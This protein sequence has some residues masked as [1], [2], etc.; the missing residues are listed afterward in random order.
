MA[1]ND[2]VKGKAKIG[3]TRSIHNWRDLEPYG[4]IPLTSE[5]CGLSMR[6]LID[7][8][9]DALDILEGFFGMRIMISEMDDQGRFKPLSLFFSEGNNWNHR[10]G[11]IAS[12]ML[13]H[14]WWREI[15]AYCLI[16]DG[17]EAVF[18]CQYSGEHHSVN[19]VMGMPMEKWTEMRNATHFD[20]LY[21]G[22]RWRIYTASTAPGT[23]LRNT[24]Y[25]SQ[26]T[27]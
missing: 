24:H 6:L 25:M 22:G 20:D 3:E 8:T 10:Q 19:F 11:Q 2:T 12:V 18:D 13:P 5:A 23:G 21:G 1:A 27:V 9:K 7:L 4:F 17:F 26:R 16:R 15:A 14:G